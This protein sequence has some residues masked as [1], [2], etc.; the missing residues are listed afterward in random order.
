MA[1]TYAIGDRLSITY[2]NTRFG[3]TAVPAKITFANSEPNMSILSEIM[4]FDKG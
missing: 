2:K 4:S 3:R 1:E